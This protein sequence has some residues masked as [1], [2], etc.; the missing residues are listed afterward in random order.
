MAGGKVESPIARSPGTN[1]SIIVGR[2][3]VQSEVPQKRPKKAC[4]KRVDSTMWPRNGLTTAAA[5]AEKMA[6]RK[7]SMVA[8]EA[9]D[10]GGADLPVQLLEQYDVSAGVTASC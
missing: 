10:G 1:V 3:H 4:R 7:I 6:W 5:C 9:W 2:G 8:D